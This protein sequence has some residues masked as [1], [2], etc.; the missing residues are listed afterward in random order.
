MEVTLETTSVNIF[1]KS[2]KENDSLLI[3]S[4]KKKIA[5][6]VLSWVYTSGKNLWYLKNLE[7]IGNNFNKNLT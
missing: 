5:F 6:M 2:N 1:Q 3:N 7:K 4:F